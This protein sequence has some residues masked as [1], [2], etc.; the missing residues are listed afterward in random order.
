MNPHAAAPVSPVEM[1]KSLWSHRQ[2]LAQ[3]S[4]REVASRY[5]GATM[6][7]A[8]SF[9]TPILML[10][11]YTFVFSVVFKAR[12]GAADAPESNA[13]FAII[14]F[15][16][17]VMH[18][19]FAEVINRAPSLVLGNVNYVKKVVFPLEI[20]PGVAISSALFH[21]CVSLVVLFSAMLLINGAVHWTAVF[22]PM[23]VLPL[24]VLT[25]G[26][27]W[28]L[29]ALGVF[30]RDVT[31][32]TSIITMVMLFLA[33][34]FY[35]IT[36]IPENYRWLIMI[37]PLTFIIEQSRDVIIWGRLPDFLGLAVYS[38]VASIVAW[39]GFAWF[40]KTRKG[41]ADVL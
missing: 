32:V 19:L 30:L 31:Q 16:G 25:L 36:A 22:L 20:L 21:M 1:I 33:P 11:V 23:V 4:R 13:Q 34:V 5:K 38:V 7:V 8:W 40:Q 14:M 26:L 15:V 41:F 28:F 6:G 39:L 18:G 3:L 17:I 12:W 35:P 9:I 2:L 29:A 27:A 24:V 37:N 10:A